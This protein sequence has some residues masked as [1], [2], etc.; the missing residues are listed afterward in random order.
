MHFGNTVRIDLRQC[1]LR[2]KPKFQMLVSDLDWDQSE[3]AARLPRGFRVAL[4]TPLQIEF[5]PL[6]ADL[7]NPEFAPARRA[8]LAVDQRA[9]V[10]WLEQR[11][12]AAL[13]IVL[14]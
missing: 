10:R 4:A 1:R 6:S 3:R 8:Y 5:G 14:R 11:A 9:G 7:F 2:A 12:V 13:L